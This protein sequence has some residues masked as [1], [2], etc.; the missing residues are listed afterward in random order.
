MVVSISLLIAAVNMF[1]LLGDISNKEVSFFQ[2]ILLDILQIPS[3]LG[4]IAICLI[5]LSTIITLFS[6]SIRSEI[7]FMRASGISIFQITLPI[8]VAVFCVGIF[9]LLIFDPLSITANKKFNH[10][11]KTLIAGEGA[12]LFSPSGGIWFKQS[13]L[14]QD[15]QEIVIRAKKI[16]RRNLRIQ[17]VSLW[18]FDSNHRFYKRIDAES[19]T[20]K[21]QHWYV[22]NV[23]LNDQNNINKRIVDLQIP[24]NL[25][26]DFITKKILN[27]F[28]D[29]RLFSIYELPNLIDDLKSSGF[30]PRKFITHYNLMLTKPFIFVAASLI[31]TFFAINNVRGKNNI[32]FFVLGVIVSLVIYIL[33]IMISAFASS[34]IIPI[35]LSTWVITAMLLALGLL[36]IFK[37]ENSC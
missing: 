29:V 13:N 3:F 28:E 15:D 31:A 32:L 18:F 26:A 5:M 25:K 6:L 19:A 14:L 33:S 9:Y 2:I 10:M 22:K 17:N 8:A 27:N 35:V 30:S 37:K 20:L 1:D 23:V 4:D 36:L 24:T 34:G 7:T 12:D 16:Y 21:N 11:Y